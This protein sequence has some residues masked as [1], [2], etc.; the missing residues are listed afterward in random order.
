M[1]TDS[2]PGRR[3]EGYLTVESNNIPVSLLFNSSH[4]IRLFSVGQIAEI[5]FRAESDD[6]SFLRERPFGGIFYKDA[7]SPPDQRLRQFSQC[8]R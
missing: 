7:L 6:F 5:L 8:F 1:Q 2:C 3:I 4:V